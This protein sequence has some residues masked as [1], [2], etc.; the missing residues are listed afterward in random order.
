MN[1]SEP[2]KAADLLV[3]NLRRW[4]QERGLT[5]DELASLTGIAAARLQ[6]IEAASAHAHLDEM[7]LLALGLGVR[8]AALFDAE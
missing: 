7:S 6:A 2:I 8:I 1:P 4:R 3:R 5:I